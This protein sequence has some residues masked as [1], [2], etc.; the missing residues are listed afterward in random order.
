MDNKLGSKDENYEFDLRSL[1]KETDKAA[2]EI[3]GVEYA[4]EEDDD[5]IVEKPYNPDDIRIYHKF[6]S[7]SDICRWMGADP[8]TIT[9]KP[10]FQ[11]NLVWTP[12]KKSLLIESLMLRI[13][14]PSFY[15]YEDENEHKNVIDGL[16]RLSAIYD[17]VRGEYSLSGLQYL[18]DKCNGKYYDNLEQKYI[19]RI[20]E[21]QLSINILDN[22]T[23]ELVKYEVFTRVNTG[24]IPLNPQ[25]IRN[26]MA[27]NKTTNLLLKMANSEVF[28]EATRGRVKDTR[29]DA[30]ELCLRFITFY[31]AYDD[32]TKVPL[33]NKPIVKMLDECVSHLNT[34]DD[35]T[36]CGYYDVFEAAMKKS[37]AAFGAF[38]FIKPG[39]N[40][41]NRLLFTSWAVTLAYSGYSCEMLDKNREALVESFL[42]TIDFDIE[43]YNAI[44]TSTASKRSI[45]QQYRTA[46]RILEEIKDAD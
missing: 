15:F 12:R 10:S 41:I 20:E 18:G 14:I 38:A 28:V 2:D 44:T 37:I 45:E 46:Y 13:P 11:R 19:S 22:R 5:D 42:E 29:M 17:Y 27:H 31:R 35:A 7:V 43:Y 8:P 32:E 33:K 34:C 30:Q 4:D 23:P 24:G 6:F 3:I 36:L 16:Q 40:V 26:A 25:E 21:T 39:Q 9:V 1:Q